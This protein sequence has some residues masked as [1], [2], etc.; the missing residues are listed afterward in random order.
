LVKKLFLSVVPTSVGTSIGLIFVKIPTEVGTTET[1]S[2][3]LLDLCFFFDK[4][5]T[6]VGTTEYIGLNHHKEKSKISKIL[7]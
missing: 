6:E 4:I 5:P 7:L 1:Q 3:H 2:E